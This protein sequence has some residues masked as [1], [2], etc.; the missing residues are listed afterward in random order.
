MTNR[1]VRR[2]G[3]GIMIPSGWRELN[4]EV[5]IVEVGDRFYSPGARV[6]MDVQGDDVGC[7]AEDYVLV[8]RKEKG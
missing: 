3:I 1:F 2:K 6:F 8:I 5:G 7:M 4:S